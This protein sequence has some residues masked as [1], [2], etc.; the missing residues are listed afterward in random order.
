MKLEAN[1]LRSMANAISI[2]RVGVVVTQTG[3]HI[4]GV[5]WTMEVDMIDRK[6][7]HL[8]LLGGSR[9]TAAHLAVMFERLTGRTPTNEEIEVAQRELDEAYRRQEGPSDLM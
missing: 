6:T 7:P 8:H 4:I 1:V 2:Q 3:P 9:I 5:P